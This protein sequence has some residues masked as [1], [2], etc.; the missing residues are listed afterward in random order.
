QIA[1]REASRPQ[2][3]NL[4]GEVPDVALELVGVVV[5]LQ[6]Q[7]ECNLEVRADF[8]RWRE[9]V[10]RRF[11]G[12]FSKWCGEV[13]LGALRKNSG[14]YRFLCRV[15]GRKQRQAQAKTCAVARFGSGRQ[16]LKSART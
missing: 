6:E 16:A 14:R 13:G 9:R 15:E 4:D 8:T 10:P 11:H 12:R 3:F 5:S 2:G 1:V 7:S